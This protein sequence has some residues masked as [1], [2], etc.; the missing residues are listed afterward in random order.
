MYWP[1]PWFLNP[2]FC[3]KRCL[4]R[5][6]GVTAVTIT[7]QGSFFFPAYS[8]NSVPKYFSRSILFG[9]F[10]LQ[11]R[12]EWFCLQSILPVHF[13]YLCT[14]TAKIW[15]VFY[16]IK[17]HMTL[18]LPK[19]MK[20]KNLQKIKTFSW[21]TDLDPEQFLVKYEDRCNSDEC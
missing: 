19:F 12:V 2:I 5:W 6:L 17:C 7:K 14:S 4:C 3:H 13:V 18:R 9:P 16:E 15:I 11:M 1:S 21:H 20:K 10:W 8:T